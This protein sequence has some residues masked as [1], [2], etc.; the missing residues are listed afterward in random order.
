M[1]LQLAHLALLPEQLLDISR[2]LDVSTPQGAR[3]RAIMVL[4]FATGVRRSEL[5]ALELSDV[6]FAQKGLR[7]LI[8][9]SMTDQVAE[10]REICVFPGRRAETCPVRVLRAWLRFRGK[11]EGPLFT[12][13]DT[14]A[15]AL[16]PLTGHSIRSIVQRCAEL[17]GLDPRDYGGHSLRA[18]MITAAALNGAPDALVMQRSGHKS[19]TVYQRYVRQAKAFAFD[20]LAKAL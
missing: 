2:V 6:K 12:R 10:G 3:D 15:S 8:R 13:L 9:R 1:P 4:G 5:A 18:G 7:V 11:D 17:T 19:V 20:P 14:L 16:L